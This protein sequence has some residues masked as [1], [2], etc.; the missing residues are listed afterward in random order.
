M[1]DLVHLHA[2]PPRAGRVKVYHTFPRSIERPHIEDINTFHLSKN[3]ETFE[4]GG[5]LEIGR[6]RS[7]LSA[8]TIE[9]FEGLDLWNGN[10]AL[11]Y[12]CA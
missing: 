11:G 5:L 7:C 10:V 4:T 2:N 9:V 12:H 1:S 8:G 6:D 3:F